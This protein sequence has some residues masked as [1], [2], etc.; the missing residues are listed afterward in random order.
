M[1]VNRMGITEIFRRIW[2]YVTN[3]IKSYKSVSKQPTELVSEL[4]SSLQQ[5]LGTQ[6]S[7][8]LE[9]K[10]VCNHKYCTTL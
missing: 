7:K 1:K 5:K 8:Y 9:G 4:N 2:L 10:Q 6:V 3:K